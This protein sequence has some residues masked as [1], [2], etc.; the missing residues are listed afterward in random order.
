MNE[1]YLDEDIV[2]IQTPLY[3]AD[4]TSSVRFNIEDHG[5]KLQGKTKANIMGFYNPIPPFKREHDYPVLC[6]VYKKPREDNSKIYV[7][8][9]NDNED[10]SIPIEWIWF[11]ILN[12]LMISWNMHSMGFWGFGRYVVWTK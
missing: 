9:Y 1:A 12:L 6:L 2:T 11:R 7:T 8:Y 10:V 5:L 4:V 3:I